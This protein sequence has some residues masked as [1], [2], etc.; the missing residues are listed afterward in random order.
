MERMRK[1][2]IAL[3]LLMACSSGPSPKPEPAGAAPPSVS[4]SDTR[5]RNPAEVAASS[6]APASSVPATP[7]PLPAQPPGGESIPR[8]VPMGVDESSMDT[9]VDPCQDFYKFACGNW[10]KKNPIPGD[11]A[12]WGRSFTTILEHN[13]AILRQIMEA[14]ARGEPDPADPY[15]KKVGDFYATCM[16]EQKAESASLQT[17]HEVLDE[18]NKANDPRS[19]AQLVGRLHNRGAA[20]FFSLAAQQDFKD[21]THV[22][23][24]ANQGGLGLPDRDYYLQ[25]DE[26]MRTV[27]EKYEQHVAKMLRLAGAS[28][29]E[30]SLHA[31]KVM[32]IETALAKVSLERV[33]L[34]DPYNRDHRLDRKGLAEKA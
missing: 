11:R 29:S 14:D 26:K 8:L 16:D 7:P 33:K 15:A 5:G 10:L 17:L 3:A 24:S 21:A 31:A 19:L 2:S 1:Q 18:V 20:P 13:E 6:G 9:T 32:K 34:R 27:R 30:A 28:E 23:G 25:D 12:T 4:P 22:I